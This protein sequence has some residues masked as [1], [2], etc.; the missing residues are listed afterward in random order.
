MSMCRCGSEPLPSNHSGAHRSGASSQYHDIHSRMAESKYDI[1]ISYRRDGGAQY[2]RILQL[3]LQQ[4][5][6]KVFLDYDELT[7]GV[8][9][10]KIISAIKVAPVFMLVLSKGSM[11]RCANE[12][13]WV[14]REMATAIEEHKHI[15]PIN[16]DNGFDGFPDGIPDEIRKVFSSHQHSDISFGQALGATIDLMI[17]NRLEPTLGKRIPQSHK[18]EN[19]DMAKETLR[20][21][22][23]HN[24]FMKGVG[25][26][27]SAA[28]IAIVVCTCFFF[29]RNINDRDKRSA[30]RTELQEKHKTFLLQLSPDL[31]V[32]Q[33]TIIDTILMNMSEVYPDSVW[34]SQ[35]EF[36]VGQWYGLKGE[37]Y[38]ISLS[39]MPMTGMSF[40]D[41][42]MMLME[43][44]DMTNLQISLPDAEV[45]KYAARGG[46]YQENTLY[47]GSNDVEKVAWYKD[48]SGGHAHPSD[49]QQGKEPNMLDLYDMSGNVGELCNSRFEDSG[50]YTVCG[51]DFDSPASEVTAN[52]CKGISTD[53]KDPAVGFRIIISKNGFHN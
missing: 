51:G 12:G 16:P 48:N 29:W 5:G 25:I 28:V 33:M 38:D 42:G 31:S 49:G 20:K 45:W 2:A 1:F 47:T 32:E 41:I 37:H 15:I 39:H 34:M 18:D 11:T 43:L 9:S 22:D 8:F 13:D 24:R 26:A 6:Y 35:F 21:M 4:R 17:S 46:A 30:M 44:G 27:C 23:A 50:L 7:D 14:R 36:S 53:A 3:M 10:E 52:S 19:F 40:G